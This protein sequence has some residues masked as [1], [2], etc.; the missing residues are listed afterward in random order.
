M[1]DSN[2]STGDI[3]NLLT[4]TI[5]SVVPSDP[6]KTNYLKVCLNVLNRVRNLAAEARPVTEKLLKD[7]FHTLQQLISSKDDLTE[8]FGDRERLAI[9]SQTVGKYNLFMSQLDIS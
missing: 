6:S 2:E 8:I 3:L 5:A 1:S 4:S 9:V 7:L